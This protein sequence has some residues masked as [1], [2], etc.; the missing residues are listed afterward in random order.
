MISEIMKVNKKDKTCIRDFSDI[1]GLPLTRS[2][3]IFSQSLPKILSHE[4]IRKPKSK[5]KKLK[6]IFEQEF[7]I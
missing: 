6:I 1:T 7:N 5:D 3:G 4:I 2:F